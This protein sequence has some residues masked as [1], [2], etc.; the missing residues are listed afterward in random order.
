MSMKKSLNG[1]PEGLSKPE[2][3]AWGFLSG[4]TAIVFPKLQLFLKSEQ[5]QDWLFCKHGENEG[6]DCSHYLQL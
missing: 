2:G 1:A 4:L 6:A 3:W 5:E